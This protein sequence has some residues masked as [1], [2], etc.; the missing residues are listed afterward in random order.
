MTI[1]LTPEEVAKL[2]ICS[3]CVG[4]SFLSNQIK[5]RGSERVCS[6][7]D[8]TG[9]TYSIEEMADEIQTALRDHYYLTQSEPDLI[10]YHMTMDE[11]VNYAWEREGE[12][13]TYV[14]G[15]AA[16]VSDEAAEDIRR[17]LEER[18]A[19]KEPSSVGYDT[20]FDSEAYYAESEI[21]DRESR[22]IWLHLE[23]SL[24]TEARYFNP[25][26]EDILTSTFERI[27][28]HTTQEGQPVIVDAG[29]G[30]ALTSFYRA[31]VFQSALDLEDALKRPD[32][33]VGPPPSVSASHGRMNPHGVSVFYGATDATVA[34]AETRPPVDSNV[35]V[36][37][38]EITRP[39]KLLDI[40]ALGKLNV[41]GSIFDLTLNGFVKLSFFNG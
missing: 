30:T 7:C 28:E 39:I 4:E 38:F 23:Q 27:A 37:R 9:W 36:G 31:R 22:E 5:N 19:D 16:E 34:L 14:I 32:L 20:A 6:Y 3:E 29:Q 17:V 1:E 41:V 24:I 15:C 18:D 2:R 10:Q 26:A 33:K 25:A 13:V 12:P 11:E 21:D 40:E 35:V 8:K